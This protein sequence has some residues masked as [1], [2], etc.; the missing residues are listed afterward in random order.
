[1]DQTETRRKPLRLRCYDYAQAGMYFV[2]ICAHERACIFG[3][4]R[5]GAMHLNELGK[6]IA[7]KW[8]ALPQ[9]HRRLNIDAYVIMPN[10]LHGIVVFEAQEP[11]SMNRTPTLG[12]VVRAFKARCSH[13]LGRGAI[14]RA[15]GVR[16]WQRGYY[17][18]V[19]RN[20]ADLVRI[21][22]YIENNP[23]QWSLD[24][25]NPAW[26]GRDESRPYGW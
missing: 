12:E 19:I 4:V 13:A 21:R 17:E 15:Q 20:E 6:L 11:G 26:D 22:E 10:H 18:H 24:R 16:L 14:H 25:N 5:D 7:E 8:L 3:K 9:Q 2:T 1:M 23:L